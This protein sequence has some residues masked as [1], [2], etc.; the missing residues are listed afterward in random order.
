MTL[1]FQPVRIATRWDEEG[2]LVFDEAQR[3]VALLTHLAEDNEVAPGQWYLEAGFGP[4]DGIEHPTFAD[5]DEAQD[6]LSRRL[7]RANRFGA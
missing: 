6:W 7:T 5:L 3:L 2:V 4:V 1:A